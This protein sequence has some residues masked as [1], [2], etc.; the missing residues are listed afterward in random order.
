MRLLPLLA[1]I[2]FVASC[3]KATVLPDSIPMG[4]SDAVEITYTGNVIEVDQSN[5]ESDLFL[6]VNNDGT[7]DLRISL[8]LGNYSILGTQYEAYIQSINTA[9]SINA[10]TYSDTTW[11]SNTYLETQD[12]NGN[13]MAIQTT[14]YSCWKQQENSPIQNVST[15][16]S[17]RP[18][19]Q[20]AQ[21]S[22]S[23]DFY[24][25]RGHFFEMDS[26]TFQPTEFVVNGFPVFQS[27]HYI[28]DCT[29]YPLDVFRYIGFKLEDSEGVERL[30]WVRLTVL[31]DR[32]ELNSHAIQK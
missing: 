20:N 23:D 7:N 15:S 17:L 24:Q 25:I 9:C 26:T 6:D 31:E 16:Y 32:V 2:V 11:V 18:L 14:K 22:L 13:P 21:L 19:D 27:R 4:E 10:N 5:P 12:L 3:K 29:S 8:R 30:G 28:N 1:L